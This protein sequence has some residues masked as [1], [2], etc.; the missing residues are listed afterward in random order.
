MVRS[1]CSQHYPILIAIFTFKNVAR[2]RTRVHDQTFRLQGK[3]QNLRSSG[4]LNCHTTFIVV[5][6]LLNEYVHGFNNIRKKRL[7]TGFHILNFW[8]LWIFLIQTLC[9]ILIQERAGCFRKSNLALIFHIQVLVQKL[10]NRTE[11]IVWKTLCG[12][13]RYLLYCK[14]IHS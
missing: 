6:L 4:Y 10:C 8:R 9:L 13:I 5:V 3:Y 1:F 7:Q 12:R 11:C 2:V 14:Q